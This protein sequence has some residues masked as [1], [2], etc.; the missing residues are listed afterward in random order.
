MELL[1]INK[2]SQQGFRKES[3]FWRSYKRKGDDSMSE[4]KTQAE[5][6][7]KDVWTRNQKYGGVGEDIKPLEEPEESDKSE[8]IGFEAD[9]EDEAND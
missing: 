1:H 5:R 6:E 4:K 3:F 8:F 7:K 9:E 2:I